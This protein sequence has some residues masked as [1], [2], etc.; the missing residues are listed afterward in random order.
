MA[1][2]SI[3]ICSL[4]VMYLV[5]VID[6]TITDIKILCDNEFGQ[7]LTKFEC[8]NITCKLF[9]NFNYVFENYFEI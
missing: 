7:R 8:D 6:D 5:D 2:K 9:K 3:L 1:E 4:S